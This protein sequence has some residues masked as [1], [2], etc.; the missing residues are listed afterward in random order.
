MAS[1]LTVRA[2]IDHETHKTWKISEETIKI[3]FKLNTLERWWQQEN[4]VSN[5]DKNKIREML[6]NL[7]LQKG[8]G[9][10]SLSLSLTNDGTHFD[11][12]NTDPWTTIVVINTR[13]RQFQHM[14]PTASQETGNVV[15]KRG[16][17]Y[18]LFNLHFKD[19]PLTCIKFSWYL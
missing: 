1:N 13:V 2:P 14:P 9:G 17:S 4:L 6:Q 7:Y 12:G 11:I 8:N 16:D 19:F 10:I 3:I 5:W 18:F 15:S